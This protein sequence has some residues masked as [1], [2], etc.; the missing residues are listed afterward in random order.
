[1]CIHSIHITATVH[2]CASHARNGSLHA[3]TWTHSEDSHN[4]LGLHARAYVQTSPSRRPH[5]DWARR[6]TRGRTLATPHTRNH[7]H[8]HAQTARPLV[9]RQ[10]SKLNDEMRP[11]E[12]RLC[13]SAASSPPRQTPSARAQSANSLSVGRPVQLGRIDHP[14]GLR[15]GVVRLE[16][17]RRDINRV[18][19]PKISDHVESLQSFDD[20]VGSEL[21]H[22]GE[23]CD[24][25]VAAVLLQD[26]EQRVHP[27]AAVAHETE[28]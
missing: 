7:H 28:I 25:D 26:L 4:T 16:R 19:S 13:I 14:I 10:S 8:H 20:I 21:G 1:M 18:L 3:R 5:R 23:L 15:L 24:G 6:R 27:V 9:H 11:R 22:V 17:L 2:N 12:H